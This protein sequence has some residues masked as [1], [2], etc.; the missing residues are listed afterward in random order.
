MSQTGIWG[1]WQLSDTGQFC[2]RVANSCGAAVEGSPRREPWVTVLAI[3][4]AKRRK[5]ILSDPNSVAPNGVLVM[6]HFPDGSR[7]GLTLFRHTVADD[8]RTCC[9]SLTA[10]AAFMAL[11][12]LPDLSAN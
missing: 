11:V 3:G 8:L 10:P 9:Q 2:E 4:A 5:E 6:A 1:A 7:R 12:L